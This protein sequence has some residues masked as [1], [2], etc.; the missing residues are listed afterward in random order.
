MN[1]EFESQPVSAAKSVLLALY[2]KNTCTEFKSTFV[3][4]VFSK[5]FFLN[6]RRAGKLRRICIC[7]S[8]CPT[9]NIS[10]VEQLRAYYILHN[11]KL[12]RYDILVNDYDKQYGKDGKISN[13]AVS[14]P[15]LPRSAG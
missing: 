5:V 12:C 10:T 15:D 3:F 4:C 8:H 2:R 1:C 14:C 7:V 9:K 6:P 13:D 11:V